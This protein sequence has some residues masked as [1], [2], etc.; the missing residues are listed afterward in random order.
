VRRI[1]REAEGTPLLRV[2]RG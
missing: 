1:G 2:H